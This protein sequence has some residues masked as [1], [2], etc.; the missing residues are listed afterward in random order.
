MTPRRL[1]CRALTWRAALV[2]H[3]VNEIQT[4]TRYSCEGGSELEMQS[5]VPSIS[6]AQL[7]LLIKPSQLVQERMYFL[8]LWTLLTDT[9]S[10]NVFASPTPLPKIDG[11]TAW[12]QPAKRGHITSRILVDLSYA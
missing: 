7:I 1:S 10:V 3:H 8:H 6:A 2:S 5:S 9:R 4:E 12:D 11:S